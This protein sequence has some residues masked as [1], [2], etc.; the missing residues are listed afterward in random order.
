MGQGKIEFQLILN[1]TRDWNIILSGK[2]NPTKWLK[3]QLILNPTRDWNEFKGRIRAS[4]SPVPI[5][6]KPY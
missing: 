3:F 4:V 1:P 2:D 6:L 5:N